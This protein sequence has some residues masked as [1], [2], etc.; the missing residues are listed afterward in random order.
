MK[1]KKL[2]PNKYEEMRKAA[3]LLRFRRVDPVRTSLRFMSIRRIAD[4]L[5]LSANEIAHL[6]RQAQSGRNQRGRRRDPARVLEQ[7]HIDFL[8]SERTLE[9]QAGKTLAE[10]SALFT[11]MFP[12]KKIAVTT[13]RC[14]YLRHGIKRKKVELAKIVPK[15]QLESYRIWKTKLLEQM[16]DARAKQLPIWYVD[17]TIFSK[18]A[19]QTLEWSRRRTN[20]QVDQT[21]VYTGYRAVI[22]TVSEEKGVELIHI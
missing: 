6:C 10:R 3:L 8:T 11:Q 20:L 16:A 15:R 2:P 13:L 12:E 21:Q 9:R 22:A 18:T 14:L 4:T 17:E 1:L 19:M 5:N 7:P